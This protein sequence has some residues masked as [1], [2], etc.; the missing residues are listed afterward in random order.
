MVNT[1]ST[2]FGGRLEFYYGN[3]WG[4]VC[5]DGWSATDAAVACRQLGFVGVSDK[6]EYFDS[7]TSSQRIWL[8]DVNCNGPESRLIDCSN[9]GIGREDCDHSEDVGF[10]C[11]NGELVYSE[12][13]S[14]CAI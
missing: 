5:D 3:E 7:G 8:D 6:T 14:C 10:V 12:T 2:Q 13:L 4:T 1:G 9:A 11:T